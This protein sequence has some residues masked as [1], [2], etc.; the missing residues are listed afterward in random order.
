LVSNLTGPLSRFRDSLTLREAADTLHAHPAHLV[1]AFSRAFG[2]SPHQYLTSRRID[3]ARRLLLDGVPPALAAAEAGFYDQ[4][5]LN[6][7]FRHILGTKPR[8]VRPERIERRLATAGDLH[9]A[10]S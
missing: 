4:P 8:Q 3:L 6:R 10:V 1:R 9:G 5:H 2:M 7:H